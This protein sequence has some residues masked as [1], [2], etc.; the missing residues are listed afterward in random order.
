VYLVVSNTDW[1]CTA[2]YQ[3]TLGGQGPA[4]HLQA[5]VGA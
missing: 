1:V 3:G 4:R 2:L 5:Q